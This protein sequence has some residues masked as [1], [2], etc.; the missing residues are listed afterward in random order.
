MQGTHTGGP[1]NYLN[2]VAGTSQRATSISIMALITAHNPKTPDEVK[3]LIEKHYKED[4]VCG[5]KSKGTLESFAINLCN[6]QKTC[7]KYINKYGENRTFFDEITCYRF[8]FNLFC[9]ASLKGKQQEIKSMQI[10]DHFCKQKNID[11]EF[12]PATTIDEFDYA[13]DYK[14]KTSAGKEFGIQVKPSSF[15]NCSSDVSTTQL[16]HD[17]YGK[18]VLFHVYNNSP[19]AFLEHSTNAVMNTI[20]KGE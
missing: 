15:F 11:V 2:R 17:S 1:L 6:A 4:C 3:E 19:P 7:Q 20:E 8:M 18:P 10:I 16:K 9:V 5:I 13:I 14:V 12:I